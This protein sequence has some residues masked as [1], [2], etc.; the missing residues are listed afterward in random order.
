MAPPAKHYDI[1]RHSDKQLM[2]PVAGYFQFR[3]GP[4]PRPA[5]WDAADA[6][7]NLEPALRRMRMDPEGNDENAW[8]QAWAVEWNDDTESAHWIT[9][10]PEKEAPAEGS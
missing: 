2:V 10:H 5:E 4:R 7:E 8:S 9:W 6:S 3:T 1:M